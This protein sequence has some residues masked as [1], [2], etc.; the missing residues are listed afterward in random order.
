MVPSSTVDVA[1][2]AGVL[3]IKPDFAIFDRF[4]Y[5]QEFVWE[6][7]AASEAAPATPGYA[8]SHWCPNRRC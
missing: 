5:A 7:I 8:Q 1:L 2:A 4:G 6:R 3:S